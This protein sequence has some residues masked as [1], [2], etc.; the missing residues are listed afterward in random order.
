MK[1]IKDLHEEKL[2]LYTMVRMYKPKTMI[3]IGVAKGDATL[4]IAM[5]MRDNHNKDKVV[6]KLMS[7][8]NWSRRHGGKA[9]S[10]KA[11]Q[12]Q[13]LE[14]N[15]AP[16]VEF[17][18]LDSQE[19]LKLQKTNSRNIVL[20]DGDHSYEGAL[21]DICEALRI[22]SKLVIVH[23]A[24]NLNGVQ[25]ACFRVDGDPVEGFLFEPL[26]GY[27]I[28]FPPTDETGLR[29]LTIIQREAHVSS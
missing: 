24:S 27:W 2:F 6:G 16:Y 29:R 22:A 3:E 1:A 18:S 19:F 25:K 28:G 21:A 14:S 15:C 13:L 8:D 7:V 5:A 12:Q 10:P 9:S 20:V 26:R 23:D 17:R 11:A 4:A